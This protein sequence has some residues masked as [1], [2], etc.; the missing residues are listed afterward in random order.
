[1]LA[2]QGDELVALG[3][4]RD[5]DALLVEP[6]LDLAVAPAIEELIAERMLGRFGGG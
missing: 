5:L 3:A 2:G 6:F 4:L 1:M